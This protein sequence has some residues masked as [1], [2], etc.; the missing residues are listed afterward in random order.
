MRH[1]RDMKMTDMEAFLSMLANDRKVSAST[2]NQALSALLFLY[3]EVLA[4]DLPWFNNIGRP[5][6]LLS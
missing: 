4:I 5:Q 6:P 2:R 1:P 3:R